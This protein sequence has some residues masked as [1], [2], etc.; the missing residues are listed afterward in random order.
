MLNLDEPAL[1]AAGGELIV[2]GVEGVSHTVATLPPAM[3]IVPAAADPVSALGAAGFAA[4]AT[5]FSGLDALAQQEV[6][7]LGAA[8]VESVGDYQAADAAGAVI[9]G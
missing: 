2:N 3:S 7:R 6:V 5:A 4:Y 9:V 8:V 1:G